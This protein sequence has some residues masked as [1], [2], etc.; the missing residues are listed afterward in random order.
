[1]EKIK[2]TSEG[3][4]LSRIIHGHWRLSEWD[5]TPAELLEFT[6][7]VIDLGITSFDHADIYGDYSCEKLFGAALDLDQS[8]RS[9][10][11][12]I[13]KCGLQYPS[14]E[15]PDRKVKFYDYSYKHI[16]ES[17]ENSLNN[18][19]TTYL[20]LLLLHRPAPYYHPEEVAK[21]FS[22]LQRSGKVLH[23]GVSNFTP[24]QYQ[25]LDSYTDQQL[26]TNQLEI[27]P[28]EL[29]H[30]DNGNI[31][32]LLQHKIN[33]MSWS[34]FHGGSL[35]EPEDE[36]GN[37]IFKVLKK[38]SEKY[39]CP[40]EQIILSWLL[41]HPVG[42]LPI[43]GTGKLSRIKSIVQALEFKLTLEEW[44]MIYSASKGEKVP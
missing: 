28:Y 18:F 31:D 9:N 43:I 8:L 16:V 25:L 37:R 1:M 15:F 36:K 6:K 29:E 21:A 14:P 10:I 20:D 12:L 5:K 32:F 35:F 27:S 24:V 44:Y 39:D 4:T 11:Q 26:V 41:M 13:T 23:F 2:L 38:L 7:A 40:T 33:P 22:E 42:I 34:P 3:L 19:N 17:V 30:F